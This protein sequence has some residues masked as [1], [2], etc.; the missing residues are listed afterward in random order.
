[1]ITFFV[2]A[3]V[4]LVYDKHAW[5]III[6]GAILVDKELTMPVVPEYTNNNKPC[7]DSLIFY[8]IH[9]AFTFQF[10]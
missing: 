1:M 9:V 5:L 7:N 8:T 6:V 10:E 2:I 4:I 3:G